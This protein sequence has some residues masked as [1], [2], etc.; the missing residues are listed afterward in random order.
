M[1]MINP[2]QRYHVGRAMRALAPKEARM[3]RPTA[4]ANL[5]PKAVH[6]RYKQQS[7]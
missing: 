5:N 7:L 1:R 6:R 3:A 4:K 2:D